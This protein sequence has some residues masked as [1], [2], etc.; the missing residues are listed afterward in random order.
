[1]KSRHEKENPF[2]TSHQIS[3]IYKALQTTQCVYK[4]NHTNQCTYKWIAHFQ[5]NASKIRSQNDK[6]EIKIK[7]QVSSNTTHL[8]S[9][10]NK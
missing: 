7:T 4:M 2:K 8:Q 5:T 3:H 10:S 1:M 6:K 9:A